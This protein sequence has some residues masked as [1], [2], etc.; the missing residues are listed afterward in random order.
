VVIFEIAEGESEAERRW[1]H[2]PE[3]VLEVGR[4]VLGAPIEVR[5]GSG[6]P[7]LPY[8]AREARHEAWL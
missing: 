8:L 6:G 7:A 2:V 5:G 3:F 4:D 1:P